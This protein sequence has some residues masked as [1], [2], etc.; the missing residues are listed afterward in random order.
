MVTIPNECSPII[1]SRPI[2]PLVYVPIDADCPE[3]PCDPILV[4]HEW[5]KSDLYP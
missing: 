2:E 5:S 3:D 4:M 1:P